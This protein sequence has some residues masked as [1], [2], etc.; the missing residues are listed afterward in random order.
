MARI[1]FIN[2]VCYGSTGSICK[3]LYK[4]ANE[5]GHECCI[6]FGRGEA[7]KGFNTIKIDNNF[8]VYSHALK[9]RLF[10]AM[11]YGSKNATKKFVEKIE[12]FH[13]DII[14]IH[15]IHGY[16]LNIEILFEYLKKHPEIKKIWTLHDCW[17]FTGHCTH[18]ELEKCYQWQTEC[19]HCVRKDG[20]PKSMIDKCNYNYNFKKKL[21]TGVKNMMVVTPSHWLRD[22]ISKS[23]LKDYDIRVIFNGVDTNVFKPTLS[24]IKE[25]YGIEDKKIILGVASVWDCNKGLDIFISLSKMIN[26]DYIIVLIGLTPKQIKKM[27]SNIIG[28]SRTEN[29]EELV[30]W[31]SASEV[32]VNGSKEETFGLTTVEAINCGTPVIVFNSTALPEVVGNKGM[33]LQSN[34]VLELLGSIYSVSDISFDAGKCYDIEDFIGSYLNLYEVIKC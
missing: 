20:Y 25:K 1:L 17:P 32:Y 10:D 8:D 15:N 16:Y 27:P 29:V 18:Y 11:G 4:A 9:A 22:Q 6:A 30:M 21:F 23:F 3:N 24:S 13:P 26:D 5:K 7:P 19:M 34:E 2:T 12:V 33:I 14:H 31:Y 28:I